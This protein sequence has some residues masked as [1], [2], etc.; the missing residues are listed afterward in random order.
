MRDVQV[1]LNY[2]YVRFCQM[3]TYEYFVGSARIHADADRWFV[4][5]FQRFVL[6][7]IFGA[8]QRRFTESH[9]TLGNI[10]GFLSRCVAG[11]AAYGDIKFVGLQVFHHVGPGRFNETNFYAQIFS[12][13]FSGVY[14][15]TFKFIRF[16]VQ[17]CKGLVIPGHT[18]TDIAS[19]DDGI[20]LGRSGF[21]FLPGRIGR[22]GCGRYV[23]CGDQVMAD[24][25]G[26][27]QG[28]RHY[29]GDQYFFPI[30]QHENSPP[31]LVWLL[32][33]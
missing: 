28:K 30:F 25:A 6:V 3:L 5:V 2:G 10:R 15:I 19:L 1:V 24:I 8:D 31:I 13:F 11:Y 7:F 26:A 29:A 22:S 14:V 9:I 32:F 12:E 33:R 20:Q 23:L 18:H 21:L 27:Y 17:I 16:W 4:D